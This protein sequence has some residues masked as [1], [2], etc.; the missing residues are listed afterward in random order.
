M[1]NRYLQKDSSILLR[2]QLDQLSKK[3]QNSLGSSNFYTAEQYLEEATRIMATFYRQMGEPLFDQN[4][5]PTVGQL[6]DGEAY[7]IAF[8]DIKKNLTI[9]FTE[10]E[11]LEDLILA[12]FNSVIT[13]SNRVNA[14]IRKTA[15]LIGDY[16]LYNDI[17]NDLVYIRDTFNNTEKLELG[18]SLLNEKQ[19]QVNQI[20]GVIT[21][22]V[23]TT[24]ERAVPVYQ[25]PT[26]KRITG[27]NH[28]NNHELGTAWNGDPM[29]ILDNNGDTWFEYER[30]TRAQ[31]DT[32]EPLKLDIMLNLGAS[33]IVNA[34]LVNPNNFGIRTSVKIETIET[35]T[36]GLTFINIKDDIPIIG[37]LTE[38]EENIFELAPATS[39]YAGQGFYS[40]TPRKAKYVHF[41][42]SQKDPYTIETSAG[43]RLRYAIGIRDIGVYSI[44]Y[45]GKGEVISREF[46]TSREINK[47][48]LKT[49]QNPSA[50]SELA[51]IQ[52]FVSVDNGVTWKP[53]Q[54]QQETG[55]SAVGGGVAEVDRGR[56]VNPLEGI[57]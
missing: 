10:F 53:I 6:P 27:C 54:P 13:G 51:T 42:F 8:S 1:F 20:E 31:D 32:G 28:G 24:K 2:A 37:Y 7:N 9:L 50:P 25:A 45:A 40:F 16:T 19:C 38:D 21:L 57:A 30:V 23:D 11:N 5:M 22:P 55:T 46:V 34:I 35:S 15:S 17:G 26:I 43:S 3:L 12:N 47:I 41:I 4:T 52:H 48:A 44:A 36:D 56:H 14:E 39:K 33:K 18:S 29:V 49:S